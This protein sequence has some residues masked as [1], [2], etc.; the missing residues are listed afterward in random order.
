MTTP[1]ERVYKQL[2][3][4]YDELNARLFSAELPECLIT[5]QRKRGAY[6]YF[7]GGR[8]G[9]MDETRDHEIDEIA[10][11]PQYMNLRDPLET[12]STLA[13]EMVHLWQHH[14]GKP[15]KTN[16]HNREWG[17]K[18]VEIG[19]PPVGP[20]GKTTGRKVSH[21]IDPEGPFA[22]IIPSVLE[23]VD[24]DG[25]G[26]VGMAMG[27]AVK[28]GRYVKYSCTK[29]RSAVRGK[30]GLDVRCGDHGRMVEHS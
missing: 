24:L 15:T 25:V 8:F 27:P 14:K 5:L 7:C 20:G 17:R 30:P 16:P 28:S 19:L 13:H 26:D 10:L 23:L 6:G 1:T 3:R 21:R 2:D 4:A 11:N 9:N 18:M 29:C 12:L 22:E